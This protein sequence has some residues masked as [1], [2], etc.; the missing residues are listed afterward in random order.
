MT[1]TPHPN[2][3]KSQEV[4]DLIREDRAIETLDSVTD[5]VVIENGPG[6]GPWRR[7]S[8]KDAFIEMALAF[9]PLFD[10]TWRQ[11]GRCVYADDQ[12]S[13]AL[14]HETG[15]LPNGDA[16]DNRAIWIS[17]LNDEAQSERIWTVDLDSE[18]CE[19]FWERN[20]V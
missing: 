8:G 17:R 18:A 11:D 3:A 16:F 1:K 6:A 2:V 10:G 5:D 12:S 9:P 13:I 15:T 14:V 4:W 20:P 19:A 7:L